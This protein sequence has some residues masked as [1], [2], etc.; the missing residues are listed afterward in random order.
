M[1]YV[2]FV[3]EHD[4]V[5]LCQAYFGTAMHY[6]DFNMADGSAVKN[7]LKIPKNAKKSRSI[8]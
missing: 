8:S 4:N 6:G 1:N 2:F 7:T 3:R 5:K